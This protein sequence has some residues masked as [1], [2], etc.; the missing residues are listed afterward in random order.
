MLLAF[1]DSEE[2]NIENE[3]MDISPGRFIQTFIPKKHNFLLVKC[4]SSLSLTLALHIELYGDV[5]EMT[6]T[7]FI[8]SDALFPL[9]GDLLTKGSLEIPSLTHGRNLSSMKQKGGTQRKNS[10]K[11]SGTVAVRN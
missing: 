7:L 8:F 3:N 9:D 10:V 5:P 4:C 1:L 6:G 2:T 11:T